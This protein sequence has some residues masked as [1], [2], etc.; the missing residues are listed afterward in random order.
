M[1]LRILVALN[2]CIL[3]PFWTLTRITCW[4]TPKKTALTNTLPFPSFITEVAL[5]NKAFPKPFTTT[6]SGKDLHSFLHPYRKLDHFCY[7]KE[8]NSSRRPLKA[9]LS[10]SLLVW[11]W[12]MPALIEIHCGQC[13][14]APLFPPAVALVMWAKEISKI[15]S[16]NPFAPC[17]S[18]CGYSA[19]LSIPF[20]FLSFFF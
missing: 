14:H 12:K 15:G 1:E 19:G 8:M 11:V 20:F 2:T 6:F 4:E 18:C 16:W 17:L 13:R 3:D 7:L 10:F 5:V 9:D